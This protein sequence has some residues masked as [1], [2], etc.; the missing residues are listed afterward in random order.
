MIGVAEVLHSYSVSPLSGAE[1]RYHL[2]PQS[3]EPPV[4]EILKKD[5]KRLP[6][7]EGN[8]TEKFAFMHLPG[9]LSIW[10]LEGRLVAGTKQVI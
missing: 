8:W 9:F 7:F 5:R 4:R 3:K 10:Q 6:A 2:H 1:W